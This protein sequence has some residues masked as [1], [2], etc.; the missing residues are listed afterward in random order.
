VN[1]AHVLEQSR[2][3]GIVDKDVLRN[4][5]Q[6]VGA[7]ETVLHAH[8]PSNSPMGFF[9]CGNESATLGMLM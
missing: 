3:L 1:A 9:S 7:Y 6:L 2:G 5:E 8:V 4:I